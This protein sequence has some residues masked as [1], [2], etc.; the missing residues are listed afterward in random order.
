MSQICLGTLALP[1]LLAGT[2]YPVLRLCQLLLM[3]LGGHLQGSLLGRALLEQALKASNDGLLGT[4]CA[5]KTQHSIK[6]CRSRGIWHGLM[7]CNGAAEACSWSALAADRMMARRIEIRLDDGSHCGGVKLAPPSSPNR[8][9]ADGMQAGLSPPH[10]ALAA[11]L[12]AC[13]QMCKRRTAA[14][15]YLQLLRLL[16]VAL[17]LP[18][19]LRLHKVRVLQDPATNSLEAQ[20]CKIELQGREGCSISRHKKGSPL[21]DAH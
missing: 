15:A 10:A 16:H 6:T 8:L 3:P 17:Q 11:S 1:H 18:H 19:L 7:P 21:P 12:H 4:H 5:L 2:I 13:T 20:C 9:V 14:A